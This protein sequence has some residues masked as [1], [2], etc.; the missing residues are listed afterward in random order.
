VED[1]H[2]APLRSS[3]PPLRRPGGTAPHGS[4]VRALGCPH[5][6][7][8]TAW[9]EMSEVSLPPPIVV[10]HEIPEPFGHDCSFLFSGIGPLGTERM[11]PGGRGTGW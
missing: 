5:G 6:G 10:V 7:G 8:L 1:T 9:E 3:R 11:Q 4:R 2:S